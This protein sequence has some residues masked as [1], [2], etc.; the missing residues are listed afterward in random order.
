MNWITHIAAVL[1]LGL[2]LALL[3]WAM[4]RH[5]RHMGTPMPLLSWALRRRSKPTTE[6]DMR[7]FNESAARWGHLP[8]RRRGDN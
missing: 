7:A 8:D 5:T 4:R 6:D 2:P 1:L 3:F